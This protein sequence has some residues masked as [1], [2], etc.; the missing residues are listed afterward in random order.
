MN[1]NEIKISLYKEKPQA[2]LLYIKSRVVWYEATVG[3]QVVLFSVPFD[4]VGD[5]DF[6]PIMPAQL[7]IRWINNE[8]E[9]NKND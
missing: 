3:G 8:K 9:E 6:L 4:D 1:K 2:K 5:A 7:L